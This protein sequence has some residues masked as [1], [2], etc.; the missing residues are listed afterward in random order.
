[1]LEVT[2][3]IQEGIEHLNLEPRPD[4]ASPG[5]PSPANM[6]TNG[7]NYL[8]D[9]GYPPRHA[10]QGGSR[11][12]SAAFDQG[13]AGPRPD[14]GTQAR[15][16]PRPAPAPSPQMRPQQAQAAAPPPSFPP[17]Q[18]RPATVPM[19]AEEREQSLERARQAVLTSNDP[20]MQVSWAQDALTYVD[21]AMEN[22]ARNAECG[23]SRGNTP[24]VERQLRVDAVSVLSFLA[25]QHHPRAEFLRGM[26][27]EFG[28]F[29]FECDKREAYRCY[30]RASQNGYPRAE[31]RMGM[32]FEN[33]N[34]VEKAIK[35]YN[36]GIQ[37]QDSASFYVSSLISDQ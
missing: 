24:A 25:D 7:R 8:G 31:Y 5:L 1:M 6:D 10:T 13:N 36:L 33:S 17:L 34:E 37:Q 16:S 32:Q 12:P 23:R 15:Q 22:E 3:Q 14:Y 21:V 9:F 35:H 2:G 18:D 27:L 4:T 11:Q 26:W 19:S 20:E 29:G 30:S 28:K